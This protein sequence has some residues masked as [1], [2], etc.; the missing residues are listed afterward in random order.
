MGILVFYGSVASFYILISAFDVGF[1][2]RSRRFR[3]Y[4]GFRIAILALQKD[5]FRRH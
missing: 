5:G 1:W 4:F 3:V 2:R